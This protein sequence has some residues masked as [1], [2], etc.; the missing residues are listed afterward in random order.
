MNHKT[1]C[2]VPTLPS[3]TLSWLID[4]KSL[5]LVPAWHGHR[6]IA[7]SY[8]W[9]QTEMLKT[10]QETLSSLLKV[11]ALR[12]TSDLRVPRVIRHAI[13]LASKLGERH[14][15]IDSLCIMQ[16]DRESLDQHIRHMASIFEAA[17]FTI[18]AADGL[19][20][21]HG[22][23]GIKGVSDPRTLPSQVLHLSKRLGLRL[24]G[25]LNVLDS[26]WGER[27]WTLQEHIFS[28]RKLIFVR[29]S[30]QW[31]CQESRCFGDICQEK[32]GG[33]YE[34]G[35]ELE[36]VGELALKYPMVSQIEEILLQYNRR[37]LTFGTDV[38]RAVEAVFTACVEA[39]PSG[40]FLG[41]P[42]D[43][44]DMALL[45][46]HGWGDDCGAKRRAVVSPETQ[47]P[48]P[49]WTWAG[50]VGK[51]RV[52]AWRAATYIKDADDPRWKEK[53]RST[54]PMLE[55]R[56]RSDKDGSEW[57]IRGLNNA[58][59]FKQRFMGKEDGLPLGWKYEHDS[60]V[61]DRPKHYL[62]EH[63]ASAMATPYYYSHVSAPGI[64][65]WHP[66][67]IS[68]GLPGSATSTI[69]GRLL[70]A[71]TRSGRLWATASKHGRPVDDGVHLPGD[72]G[73]VDLSSYD[74]GVEGALLVDME[75]EVA[76]DLYISDK[77]DRDLVKGYER[78]PD[79]AGYPCELVAIS[80]GNDFVRPM[81][82]EKE[83]YTFYNVLWIKWEDGIAYRRG[84]GRV[85]RETWES[86]ELE[87]VD[88]IL[89]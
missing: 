60:A 67:P 45:W 84:V 2:C 62:S 33:D 59:A 51:L 24:R 37:N 17:S 47:P 35:Q 10:T 25:H 4:T 76:G 43:F 65:F 29:G 21:Y 36:S 38:I 11:G 69:N 7:L 41:L 15:W 12:A 39:Y 71:S 19:D 32:E 28:K 50:W 70:C 31:I 82:P 57:P 63:E 20:A 5:C 26:P 55:W 87:D 23:L 81:E 75:R 18:V 68:N 3:T 22:I 78:Q 53:R 58:Y 42:I 46:S 56:Y 54:I 77:A 34:M 16:D 49:S 85:K 64:K 14:L 73:Y 79:E 1:S 9:G 74:Y 72:T 30:V 89:G 13:S 66:V 8:V 61:D 44:F 86:M 83:T 88:L 27:G 40:F 80:K 48:F 6:Y 52:G